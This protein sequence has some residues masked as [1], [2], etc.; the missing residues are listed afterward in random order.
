[1]QARPGRTMHNFLATK[2]RY[3]E[4][5]GA[6]AAS[7][8]CGEVRGRIAI[9]WCQLL[10]SPGS[11]PSLDYKSRVTL[12]RLTSYRPVRMRIWCFERVRSNT[13]PRVA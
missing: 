12:C 13:G 10:R 8:A 11:C 7:G 1:M 5:D 3:V 4:D 2:L 9:C 6:V